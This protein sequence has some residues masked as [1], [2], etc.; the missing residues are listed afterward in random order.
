MKVLD[1]GRRLS[2]SLLWEL[3]RDFYHRLGDGAWST[4]TV[5][6]F[7]T[8][9]PFFAGKVFRLVR[10]FLRDFPQGAVLELGAGTGRFGFLL[11]RLLARANTPIRYIMSDFSGATVERLRHRPEL[12]PFAEHGGLEFARY[13]AVSDDPAQLD[14][15]GPLLVIANYLLD[16]LPQDAFLL[17]EGR[18]YELLPIL[19]ECSDDDS[20][21]PLERLS[22]GFEP[23]P[24]MSSVYGEPLLD[25]LLEAYRSCLKS[26]CFCLPV[27]GLRALLRL[28][29]RSREPLVLFSADK[30]LTARLPLEGL[31]EPPMQRHGGGFSMTVDYGAFERLCRSLGGFAV[32]SDRPGHLSLG[33]FATGPPET[34][35][36]TATAFE[37]LQAGLGPEDFLALHRSFREEIRDLAGSLAFLRLSGWDPTSFAMKLPGLLHHLPEAPPQVRRELEIA[38][39]EVAANHYP[40]GERWDLPFE[41][42]R[43]QLML[44]RPR[45]A[46]QQFE[47]AVDGGSTRFNRGLC[48]LDLGDSGR[49][50][51]CFR[52]AQELDP[53]LPARER[54]QPAPALG[55]SRHLLLGASGAVRN[56]YHETGLES[57]SMETLRGWTLGISRYD[58]EAAAQ[59]RA[60]SVLVPTDRLSGPCPYVGRLDAALESFLLGPG[61]W[62]PGEL[63]RRLPLDREAGALEFRNALV[64]RLEVCALRPGGFGGVAEAVMFLEEE[65]G[66]LEAG[67]TPPL[68]WSFG[69]LLPAS[70][71][72]LA[73][74]VRKLAPAGARVSISPQDPLARLLE[75]DYELASGTAEVSI[76]GAAEGADWHLMLAENPPEELPGYGLERVVPRVEARRGGASP[77]LDLD[78]LLQAVP[79]RYRALG[80]Y[81]RR[82]RAIYLITATRHLD[83][84]DGQVLNARRRTAVAL[85]GELQAVLERHRA[86]AL[87]EDS[88]DAARA[89]EAG[90]LAPAYR[91]VDVPEP[92][93][94]LQQEAALFKAQLERRFPARWS[95]PRPKEPVHFLSYRPEAILD[96]LLDS[97]RMGVEREGGSHPAGLWSAPVCAGGQD[98]TCSVPSS[99]AERALVI[100][101][102]LGVSAR[103]VLADEEEALARA[104][105]VRG[106]QVDRSPSDR[107]DYD[108]AVAVLP[109]EARAGRA[110]SALLSQVL[111]P[112]G[113]MF[114][115]LHPDLV[116]DW[117]GV[118]DVLKASGLRVRSR[119]R[120]FS[121]FPM[122]SEVFEPLIRHLLRFQLPEA[123]LR[124]LVR[125]APFF[126][127]DLYDFTRDGE[128]LS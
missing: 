97:L 62:S 73:G 125:A 18:L 34:M 56:L 119:R 118:V 6:H 72:R 51:E 120:A 22:V 13:D 39:K 109:L 77:A 78:A 107:N 27:A 64:R 67:E 21:E 28:S 95:W 29:R 53:D 116:E 113:R 2:E 57:L 24:V 36:H 68:P 16:T 43:C 59:A 79:L 61:G 70:A 101:R 54:L 117:P 58:E 103:V 91:T 82:P 71:A 19:S 4:W 23:H 37:E 69:E 121:R 123:W 52:R 33:L 111:R 50:E 110:Q 99:A 75:A 14:L 17:G 92:T 128:D 124:A 89:V 42:G 44:R 35:P 114:L 102:V 49:A 8:N 7:A 84:R 76:G 112:Q 105:E 85:T 81:A 55:L 5:P 108:A 3:Q 46:L 41:L 80:I 12:Q 94:A 87:W 98:R 93:A 11:K 74:W 38:L 40:I 31:R 15:A 88:R 10:G 96:F 122:N 48:W 1:R 86:P 65:V 32:V 90:L 63:E 45:P 106:H 25:D 66:T 9:N 100:G 47:R 26:G 126:Y 104:L 60:R 30:A 20:L 83:Y 127:G 115:S